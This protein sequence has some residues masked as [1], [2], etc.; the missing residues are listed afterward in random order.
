MLGVEPIRRR[1][2][3]PEDDLKTGRGIPAVIS[4]NC[5]QGRFGGDPEIANRKV[6][7]LAG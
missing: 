3:H 5:W 7:R 1:V 2:L 4:Y 6:G